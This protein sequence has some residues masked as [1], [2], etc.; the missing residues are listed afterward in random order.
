MS[1]FAEN[2]D[3]EDVAGRIGR[4]R[5]SDD[6]AHLRAGLQMDAEDMVDAVDIAAAHELARSGTDFFSRLEG[7]LDRTGEFILML[8]QDFQRAQQGSRMPIVS[9]GMVEPGV[10]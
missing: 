2:F 4:A 7:E 9:A 5:C 3:F 8:L 6:F 10:D 1:A